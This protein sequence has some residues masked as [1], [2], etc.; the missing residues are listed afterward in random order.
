MNRIGMR[1]LALFLFLFAL[2][3]ASEVGWIDALVSSIPG[4]ILYLI[5][6]GA[7]VLFLI[8][9]VARPILDHMSRQDSQF[10]KFLTAFHPNRRRR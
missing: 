2:S 3:A 4:L 8:L 5:I 7:C 10:A 1:V 6:M 9:G